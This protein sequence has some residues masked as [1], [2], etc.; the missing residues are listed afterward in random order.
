M[1]IEVRAAHADDADAFTRLR[2][3][4]FEAMGDARVSD[5]AWQEAARRWFAAH[6]DDPDVALRVVEVGGEIVAG[7]VAHVRTHSPRPGT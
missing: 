3:S 5:P 4:M 2:V 6:V 7:A 1:T